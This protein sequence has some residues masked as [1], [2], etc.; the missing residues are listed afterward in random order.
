MGNAV[1]INSNYL[2]VKSNASI[3]GVLTATSFVGGLTGNVTG[4]LTGDVSGN[5]TGNVTGNLTGNVN[6]SG[7]STFTNNVQLKS[8][9]GS[10][11]RIDFYCESG[12]S[13]YTRLKSA[14]HSEYSGNVSVVLPTKSGDV[15]VGDTS[16][17]ITQTINTSGSITA[18]SFIGNVTGNLREL[19]QVTLATNAQGL[20]GTPSISVVD[21][22]SRHINS[23]GVVTATSFVGDG[24]QLTGLS[25]GIAGISTTGTSVFN[26]INSS[27]VVTATTF[28]GNL[29]GNPTGTIQTAAQQILHLLELFLH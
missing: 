13:H 20:T 4:N 15:I 16:G 17:A 23:S 12:N 3:V 21:I 25:G 22:S 7:V 18:S 1:Q 10:P 24:S 8:G 26:N 6:A 11:A 27:G 2:D 29:T 19:P 14:P 5:V 28:V 9:D